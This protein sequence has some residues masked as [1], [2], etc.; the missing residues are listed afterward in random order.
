MNSGEERKEQNKQAWRA[1]LEQERLDLSASVEAALMDDGVRVQQWQDELEEQDDAQPVTSGTG[2]IPP[3]LSLQS[4]ALSAVQPQRTVTT[5]S[6]QALSASVEE[7]V[8]QK[9]VG[10][11]TR[12]A[13]RFTSSFTAVHPV[14]KPATSQQQASVVAS[15]RTFTQDMEAYHPSAGYGES[16]VPVP[17]SGAPLVRVID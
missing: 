1:H 16:S 11:L 12:L 7:E 9:S 5:T 17:Y 13:Q 14:E 3:R 4:R 2:I 6:H 8:E 10:M 15:E